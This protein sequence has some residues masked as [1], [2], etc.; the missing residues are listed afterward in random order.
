MEEW[1]K[2]LV[3]INFNTGMSG[4]GEGRWVL[5]TREKDEIKSIVESETLYDYYTKVNRLNILYM[6]SSS[7]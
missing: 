3:K 2:K 7:P 6:S 4:V 1:P 5:R